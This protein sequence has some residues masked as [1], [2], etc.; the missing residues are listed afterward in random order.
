MYKLA[1]Y[2][3]SYDLNLNYGAAH[4]LFTL[5]IALVFS[6]LPPIK[7]MGCFKVHKQNKPNSVFT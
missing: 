3:C 5:T 2:V 4:R 7:L 6:C 1:S